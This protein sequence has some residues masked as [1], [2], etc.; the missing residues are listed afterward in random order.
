MTGLGP[1]PG[2]SGGAVVPV[3]LVA[4]LV[5]AL[6]ASAVLGPRMVRA[7]APALV[8]VPRGAVWLL[9]GGAVVW[10]AVALMVG[11][12]L[13]WVV[14]GPGIL[15][16]PAARVCQACVQ[17]ANPFLAGQ[18]DA[19][20][21]VVL[22]I[23][24]S[25]LAAALLAGGVARDVRRRD[26]AARSAAGQVLAAGSRQRVLGH[27]VVVVQDER[28]LALTF[29]ARHGGIVV[30][31]GTLRRLGREEL[32]AVLVHEAAHLRQHHHALDAVVLSLGRQLRWVPLVAAVAS[33][34]PSYLEIAADDAARRRTGTAALV[35]ALATLGERAVPGPVGAP[36]AVLHAAGPERIRHLVL[37]ETGWAGV[38]PVTGVLLAL[39]ALSTFGASIGLPYAAALLHGC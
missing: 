1:D 17:A 22:L 39:T 18:I 27:E 14:T 34:V 31:S 4:V 37:P 16:E 10:T 9:L 2:A 8:R 29:P 5:L 7:A 25:V 24:P 35:R 19:G 13:A 15:P 28:P 12:L 26:R 36:E 3:V 6:L 20:V 33:A 30:S 23:A 32:R 21:P 38:V 11:P